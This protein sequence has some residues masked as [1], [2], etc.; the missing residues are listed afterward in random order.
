MRNWS[1]DTS[2]FDKNS[3]K[4]IIWK[5]EQLINFGLHGDLID[6]QQLHTFLP[7]L[8]IDPSRRKF[9]ELLLKNA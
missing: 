2:K 9:L 4:F 3:S 6:T 1:T 5:L 8:T 7:S